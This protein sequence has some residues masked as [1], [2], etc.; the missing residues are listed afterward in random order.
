[1]TWRGAKVWLGTYVLLAHLLWCVDAFLSTP[2]SG[3]RLDRAR[4]KNEQT[5]LRCGLER[6]TPILASINRR[7]FM[8]ILGG[9]S[10]IP[11][12]APAEEEVAEK[13]GSQRG[14]FIDAQDF[15]YFT[16]R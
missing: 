5:V 1:M 3:K 15:P 9:L 13:R 10:L 11:N 4:M 12:I 14:V 6:G 7:G 2:F 16:G 8:A